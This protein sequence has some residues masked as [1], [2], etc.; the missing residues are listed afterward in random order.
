[1][2]SERHLSSSWNNKDELINYLSKELGYCPCIPDA[3]IYLRDTLRLMK[4]LNRGELDHV[5]QL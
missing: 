2:E 3:P 1:M 5:W 4:S